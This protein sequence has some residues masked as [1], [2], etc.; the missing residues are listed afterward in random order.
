MCWIDEEHCSQGIRCLDNYRKA[1]DDKNGTYKSEPLH[2]WACQ[3]ADALMTGACG[4]TPEYV[5]PPEDRYR[6]RLAR[7][8]AWAA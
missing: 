2:N 3:G 5:P 6:R 8:S 4:F 1:W 7:T